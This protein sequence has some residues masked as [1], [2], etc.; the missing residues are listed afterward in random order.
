MVG[1]SDFDSASNSKPLQDRGVHTGRVTC[2]W[3]VSAGQRKG[4]GLQDKKLLFF[5]F[6]FPLIFLIQ[7]HW[8]FALKRAGIILQ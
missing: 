8:G 5:S 2:T 1:L 4:L 7:L 6:I 3:R